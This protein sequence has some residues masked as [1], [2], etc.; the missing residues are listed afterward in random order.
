[1]VGCRGLNAYGTPRGYFLWE[2]AAE[3]DPIYTTG[4]TIVGLDFQ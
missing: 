1:M 3:W 4:L 2:C